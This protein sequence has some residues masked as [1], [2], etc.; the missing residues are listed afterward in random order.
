MPEVKR[1]KTNYFKFFFSKCNCCFCVFRQTIDVK[2]LVKRLQICARVFI[3]EPRP[4]FVRALD[5]D[6]ILGVRACY[7]CRPRILV[8]YVPE[9]HELSFAVTHLCCLYSLQHLEDQVFTLIAIVIVT[10]VHHPSIIRPSSVHHPSI[11][12]PSSVHRPSIVCPSSVR[13]L[14]IVCP[15]SVRRLSVVC[16][17]S[18]HHPSVVCPSSIRPSS[19]RPSSL[20]RPVVCP[21]T[22][23]SSIIHFLFCSTG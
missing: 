17:S 7:A 11:I 6:R 2:M 20:I 4:R 22:C 12:R 13:S 16:P 10:S 8:Q 23:P 9:G 15:S 14:S 19:I 3:D 5:C 21:T 18:V 1:R